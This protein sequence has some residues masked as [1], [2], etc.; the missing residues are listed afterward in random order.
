MDNIRRTFDDRLRRLPPPSP[1]ARLVDVGAAVGLFVERARLAGWIAE[2]LEPSA[3]AAAY[4]QERL[5]QPVRAVTIEDSGIAP[6]SVDV[7]TLW[8]VIEH[9]P[10]PRATLAAIHRVLK[11]GGLLALSTPDAGSLAARA[12]GR[13]WPGWDK[14]P[15]HLF[16]FD[17]PILKRLLEHVGFVVITSEYVPLVVSRKYLL[18]RVAQVLG[19]ALHHKLSRSWLD[20]PITINPGFDLMVVARRQ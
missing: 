7:V 6:Q 4:A 10:D 18:D 8:E 14:L 5:Q 9:V 11:R 16:F 15:E 19:V 3:W 2:G 13:R 12:L 17:R 1:D 20:R